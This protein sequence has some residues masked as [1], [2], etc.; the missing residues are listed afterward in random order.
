MASIVSIGTYEGN[1]VGWEAGDEAAMAAAAKAQA[2]SAAAASSDSDDDSDDDDGAGKRRKSVLPS[3]G[4]PLQLV[5]GFRA[6]ET[7]I[8]AVAISSTGKLLV[9]A[10]ADE[11]AR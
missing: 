2:I 5:Y 1:L 8:R 7:A 11:T 6:H 4:G 3:T 10:A 9:T